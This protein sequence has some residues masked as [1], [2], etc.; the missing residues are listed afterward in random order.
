MKVSFI[1]LFF[2]SLVLISSAEVIDITIENQMRVFM[3]KRNVIGEWLA[4]FENPQ[5]CRGT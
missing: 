1:T 3:D 5:N 4:Y 2:T